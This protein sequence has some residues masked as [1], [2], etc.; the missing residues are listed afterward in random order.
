MV[1]IK[2]NGKE[3][4]VEKG[5]TILKAAE[6]LDIKIPTLCYHPLLE[7]Y[8]ACRI[9]MVEI[10]IGKRNELVTACNTVVENG[11]EIFTDSERALK[12]RKMNIELLMARAPAAEPVKEIAKELGV[13]KTRFEIKDPNEK[14]ILCGLCVRTCEQV[15]GAKAISFI[16][17]GA[18]RKVSTPF[19]EPSEDCIGCAACAYFCPTEAI[20]VE[21][22]DKREVIHD[23]MILGPNSAI[24]VPIRQAVPMVPFIDEENCIH[25]KTGNCKLCEKVCEKEAIN[26]DME[27]EEI[28]LEVGTIII[29]TG[30]KGFDA[31][32]VPAYGY[33]RFKNVLTALE[34][35]R[36]VNASGPTGGQIRLADGREPESVGIIHCV[37]SRDENFNEYCSR[38]CCMYSLKFAHIIKER[39]NAEVYNFY[40]DMRAFGKGYEEFYHKLLEEGV[41]FIRG[42]VSEISDVALTPEE[43]GKLIIRVE[44]T[45]VGTVR[46]IPVDMAI[47]SVGL[48]PN[49]G[50]DEITRMF[51]LSCSQDAFFLEKH[52]K[53][54]PVSTAA[55]GIFLAGTCQGPKD[56][57]DTV[58][59]AGAAAS[60][61]LALADKGK[62]ELEP[63]T[64]EINEELCSGC[65]L[66]IALCPFSAISYNKEK[67]ISE[68]NEALCK[69]CGTCVAACPSGAAMQN[70][71][72]DEQIIAEIE[73]ILS[74]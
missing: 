62:F 55:D 36:M 19:G 15:V 41:H 61:A 67:D 71:F 66:C 52:P 54:A 4:K 35:E 56:I 59:Q 9:C 14:C 23:E 37:G 60:E 5:T 44:D 3:T 30:F 26:H 7:P 43:E 11:M 24:R 6:K 21:D 28:E 73:G 51:N 40:I 17:R 38:V 2:I 18:D 69:G 70:H 50:S 33:G 58:A 12:A 48:E 22:L 64:A 10:K 25:F 8:S 1:K 16:E 39:T 34:F 68:V 57:P 29:A 47:L 65:Q 72:R 31:K 63:V 49:F 32:K 13:E 46:R 27:D 20:T 74:V 45:L 42:R 53:L